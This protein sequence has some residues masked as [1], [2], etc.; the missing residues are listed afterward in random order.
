MKL[1]QLLKTTNLDNSLLIGYY[2]GGN[3]GDELLLEVLGNLLSQN[4]TKDVTITYIN[5]EQYENYHRDFG[6]KRIDMQDKK[7]LIKQLFKSKNIMIGGG[8]LWGVDMN[9]NTFLL[10]LMLFMGRWLL[11][12]KVYLLGVG[13]YNSTT[14]MGRAGAWLAGKAANAII[15]RDDETFENFSLINHETYLDSDM[16]WYIDQVNLRPYEHDVTIMEERLR[17][18]QKTLVVALRRPQSKKHGH[19]FTAF[20]DH[21]GEFI[22]ANPDKSIIIAVLESLSRSPEE[23]RQAHAWREMYP[24]VQLLDFPHN[25]LALFLFFRKHH[26]D[27]AL[28]APQFHVIITAHLTNVPFSPIVY[29]NKVNALLSQIGIADNE[30]IPMKAVN[31]GIMQQFADNFFGGRS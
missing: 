24:N 17:I 12:K 13:Y 18:D 28:I 11:G 29:D 6:Y 27:L 5:P 30:R 31:L 8:G 10:S 19:E 9:F 7:Q 16:A 20:T 26:R 21:I 22:A 25:P 1:T 23:H 4:H 14:R 3:Y 15:A 2:G